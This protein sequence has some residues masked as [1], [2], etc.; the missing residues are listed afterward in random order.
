MQ[1]SISSA[2]PTFFLPPWA[3]ITLA[4]LMFAV[5]A[6]TMLDE[7]FRFGWVGFLCLG[8]YYLLYVPMQKVRLEKLTSAN[9][10]R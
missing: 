8:L 9:R 4:C 10:E 6:V 2:P 5:S 7:F 1:E 3:R